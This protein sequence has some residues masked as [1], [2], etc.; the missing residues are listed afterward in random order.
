M[1]CCRCNKQ[2]SC[3]GCVCVKEG[4]SCS[5]C[6]L[7]KCRNGGSAAAPPVSDSGASCPEVSHSLPVPQLPVQPNPSLQRLASAAPVDVASSN[8][9]HAPALPPAGP[10]PIDA[11]PDLDSVLSLRVPTLQHV[12]KAVRD[13]WA[14]ILSEVLSAIVSSPSEVGPWCKLFMLSKCLLANPPRGD[15][16]TG[17]IRSNWFGLEFRSGEMAN[18]WACG[19][20]CL[21]TLEGSGHAQSGPSRKP[22]Q[23]SPFAAATLLVPIEQWKM[24]NTRR[25]Y[26][27]SPLWAS[28]CPRLRFS[29]RCGQSTPSLILL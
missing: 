16:P 7:G 28:P 6:R 21:P 13:S 22:P 15:A 29:M 5:N 10:S 3:R 4:R 11:L 17:V 24:A 19:P 14:H 23:L 26:S 25:P 8:A 1:G 2:G 20:R 9:V 27:P 18:S 12:P